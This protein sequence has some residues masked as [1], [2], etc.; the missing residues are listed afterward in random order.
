MPT[1]PCAACDGYCCTRYSVEVTAFDIRRLATGLGV[2]PITFCETVPSWEGRCQ[3]QPSRI[4]GREVNI[5]LQRPDG[6]C[7]FFKGGPEGCG[8]YPH[9]PVSCAVFPFQF[10]TFGQISE[11]PST[12]CPT[13]WTGRYEPT[14]IASDLSTLRVEIA[15]H[16]R[17]A[18]L[19]NEQSRGELDLGTYLDRLLR[20]TDP[21]SA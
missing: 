8:V 15:A 6:A 18:T 1:S 21:T 16:N 11:R 5:V 2:A 10:A 4:G 19:L 14:S 7:T 17:S 3:I 20:M 12:P 9:R 13:T